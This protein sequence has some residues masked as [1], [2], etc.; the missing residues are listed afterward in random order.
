[1]PA[2]LGTC[3]PVQSRKYPMHLDERFNI[4]LKFKNDIKLST[5]WKC[6]Q[7]S[8]IQY[9]IYEFTNNSPHLFL[10]SPDQ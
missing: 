8:P 9:D 2:T 1:M 10:C 6:L 3:K 4:N 7:N 5:Q